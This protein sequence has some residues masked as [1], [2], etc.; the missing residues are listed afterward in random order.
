M[1]TI[2]FFYAESRIAGFSSYSLYKAGIKKNKNKDY[3]RCKD[4]RI[5][6]NFCRMSEHRGK[7]TPPR[8]ENY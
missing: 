5:A 4:M 6:V 2:A 7:K 8:T 1:G 3:R